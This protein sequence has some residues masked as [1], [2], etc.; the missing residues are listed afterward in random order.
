MLFFDEEQCS[1]V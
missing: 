1:C